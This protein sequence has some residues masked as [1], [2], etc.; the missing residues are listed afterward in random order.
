MTGKK[1]VNYWLH[2]AFLTFK[3]EKVSKSKG[4][5]YTIDELEELGYKPISYRYFTFT[6]HY[7]MPLDFTLENLNSAQNSYERLKNIV[8]GLKDDKKTNK[9]YLDDFKKAIDDDLNMPNALAVLWNLLRDKDAEGKLNTVIEMDK[10]F[11]LDLL[12]KEDV[13]VSDEIKK[14]ID[15][16]EEARKN[17]NFKRADNIRDQL[18][19]KGVI[20]ED[21]KEGIRWKNAR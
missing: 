15:Q 19:E 17:K 18:K 3:G 8:A 1:F 2:G 20:L 10:V 13:D 6:A 7:R 14:L 21:T 9:K 12:K 16:R 11:G 4:G 5:L